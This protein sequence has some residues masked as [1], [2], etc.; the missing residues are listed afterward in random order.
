MLTALVLVPA[1]FS[2]LERSYIVTGDRD[3]HVRLSRW[4]QG[5]IIDKFL[6]GNKRLFAFP[7]LCLFILIRCDRFITALAYIAPTPLSPIPLILSAGGDSALQTFNLTTGEKISSSLVDSL[8]PFIV[9][10]PEA[11]PIIPIGKKMSGRGNKPNSTTKGRGK[12]KKV[13]EEVVID[14]EEESV[15]EGVEGDL[16]EVDQEGNDLVVE[17]KSKDEGL[18]VKRGMSSWMDGKTKGLAVSKIV[19]LGS[20][21][22]GGVLVLACG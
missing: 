22:S 2:E 16:I 13:E 12:G 11:P 5:Y 8:F 4:P 14:V 3:E 15:V 1:Q 10:A 17:E 20:R 19:T 18:F 7:S 6:F 21:E 9:V